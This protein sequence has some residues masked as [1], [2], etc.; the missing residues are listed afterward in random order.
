MKERI[1]V[2]EDKIGEMYIQERNKSTDRLTKIGI[3][4]LERSILQIV[5]VEYG[6]EAQVKGKEHMFNKMIEENSPQLKEGDALEGTR[7]I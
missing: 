6:E 5:G 7:S 1:S 4:Y 2:I 3:K